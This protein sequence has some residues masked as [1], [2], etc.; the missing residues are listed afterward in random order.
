MVLSVG[1]LILA[2]RR[3]CVDMSNFEVE[4]LLGDPGI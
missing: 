3:C 4:V 2:S 1:C